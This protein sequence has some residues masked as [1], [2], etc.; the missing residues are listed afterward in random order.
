[1]DEDPKDENANANESGGEM[2]MKN[3]ACE[4]VGH[5]ISIIIRQL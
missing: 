3:K 5:S 4:N 2:V 1:M